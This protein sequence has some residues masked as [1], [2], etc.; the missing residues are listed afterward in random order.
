M[1]KLL[2]FYSTMLQIIDLNCLSREELLDLAG[3]IE[4]RL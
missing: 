3:R 1:V 2:T 4:E